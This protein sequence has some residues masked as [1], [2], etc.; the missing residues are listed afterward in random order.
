M[1]ARAP[2]IWNELLNR[3]KPSPS[4]VRGLKL[5][6]AAMVGQP[7][8]AR[9]GIEGTP[10]EYGL[11]ASVLQATGLHREAA[12]GWAFARPDPEARP[13]CAA[14][15]DAVADTLRQSAGR[16][17]PVAEIYAALGAPPYGVRPGLIPVFLLAFA[18]HARDRVAF[19]ENGAFVRELSFETVERL[20][21]SAEKGQGAFAVQ[22]VEADAGRAA[23]LATLAPLVGLPASTDQPLPVVV[24]LLGRVHE[25]PPVVRTTAGLSATATAVREALQR[26]TDPAGLLFDA[27][28]RALGAGSFLT[29][30]GDRQRYADGLGD[31][32]RE[33]GGAYDALLGDL[34]DQVAG[35][36]RLRAGDADG[37]RHEL[38]ARA[39]VLLPAATDLGLKAFL[40]RAADET[41]ATRAW[42]E[43]LAALLARTPPAQWADPDRD[44]FSVALGRTAGA[45]H[46]LE[47]LALDLASDDG[48]TG[49]AP[50]AVRR[51]R[52][53]VQTLSESE[54][55]GVVHVHPE[56]D[57]LVER[58]RESLAETARQ[59]GA[60]ADVQLAA[61]SELVSDLLAQRT[62]APARP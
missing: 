17:V 56:D 10:A 39:R 51:V 35:A 5:L 9:L 62:S 55:D 38:A 54:R 58:L 40:V 7:G 47:P 36:F 53:S 60:G 31:A 6:L 46:R 37:R 50:S 8:A 12:D 13:G 1:F 34:G 20:L 41:L 61:L 15:W 33:L 26:A 22:Y 48:D 28:P 23:L 45:F 44:A 57:D 21:K 49:A 19:F 59:S 3:R 27:L 29:G 43:S 16:P 2:E 30:D 14:V 42:A 4:A 52:L 25:L 32:L 18:V 11:Y 24:R